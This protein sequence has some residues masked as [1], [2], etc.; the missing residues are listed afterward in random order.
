MK[1]HAGFSAFCLTV[2][3]VG[4]PAFAGPADVKVLYQEHCAACHGESRLGG[5]GPALLPENLE[6]LRRPDALKVI[7]E[8]R[9]ATQMPAFGDKLD[10]DQAQLARA[11][12]VSQPRRRLEPLPVVRNQ[13]RSAVR[14]EFD[15]H[16][17]I[18]LQILF[19]VVLLEI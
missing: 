16:Q 11:R 17:R 13:Q 10:A 4:A 3:L 5:I 14:S 15:G 12:Q 18:F 6:R 9:V 8:G 1:W 2:I 19:Y 7:R